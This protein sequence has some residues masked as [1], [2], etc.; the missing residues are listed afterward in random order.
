MNIEFTARQIA[1]VLNGKLEGD[2]KVKV[3]RISKIDSDEKGCLVF[4]S[5][6][7][8]EKYL[9]T[10]EAA[11]AIVK[12]SLHVDGVVKPTL[13]R[14]KNPYFAFVKILQYYASMKNEKTGVSKRAFVAKS[15][16]IGRD[17]YIGDGA[18][19]GENVEIEDDVRIYPQAFVGDSVHIGEGTILYSGA[20]IYEECVIGSDCI[21]HSC[22]VIGADGFGFMPNEK[23]VFEKIP[24]LGNVV[25]GDNVEIGANSCIDR[26]T[27]GSTVIGNGVKI[28]NLVQI[29][30]NCS[31]GENTVIAAGCGIA[32]SVTI[33][34]N[35]IFAGQ[36]GVKDHITIGNQVIA[37]SQCGIHKNIS[38][39]QTVLGSPAMEAKKMM[40]IF[41]A[42]K[43]LPDILDRHNKNNKG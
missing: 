9:Y 14:V 32:G 16:K 1:E 25:I 31:I 13:I 20:K 17:V 5:D 35:C 3:S 24:Q 15:A 18:F 19:I 29:A 37:G 30:H 40:K 42:M 33:G 39:K 41:A 7:K 23:G 11:I 43:F 21:L 36:V 22:C 8:Y 28:D 4:V 34:K 27:V 26:S 2:E 38:D 10:T 6:S 12:D